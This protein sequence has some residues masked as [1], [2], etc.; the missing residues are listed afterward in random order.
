MRRLNPLTASRGT[1]L[2]LS[3]AGL[4]SLATL[5]SSS[6]ESSSPLPIDSLLPGNGPVCAGRT[7]GPPPLLGKLM[8]AQ[9]QTETKTSETRP[10][11]TKPFVPQPMQAA[12]GD[13]PLYDDLGSLSFKAGTANTKAQAYFDQGL[14][15]AF[16]FNHAEAQRAFRAAYTL[17]PDFAL[18]YWGEAWVLGP[19]INSSMLPEAVAPALAA[20][21]KAVERMPRAPAKDRALIAALQT[22]YSSDPKAERA[23]L[24]VAFADA[25]KAVAAKF[26]K[27]DTL[28]V[29]HAEAVMNTQPWDY[30]EAAGTRSKGRAAEV[31]RALETV[32]ARNPRHPGAIHYYIH[33]VEA[34]NRPERALAHARRLEALM[35][36]AGHL[37]HM[38]SH[39]YH[40]TGYFRESLEANKRAIA[41]DERYFK[42]SASD[43]MYRHG[44]HPHNIHFA[45]ASA[46]M[47]GDG[48][49]ALAMAARLDTALPDD[50]LA[51]FA[52][53]EP[54]KAAP[55]LAHSLFSTADTILAQRMPPKEQVIVSAL[56]HYARALAFAMKRDAS[57]A[58]T[59]IAAIAAIE[60]KA[61]FKAYLDAAVPV[62]EIVQLAR[63]VAS[64]R[65]ADAN[66]DLA[67]A[68][69]LYTEAITIE[70]TLAYSE[71]PYWHV[72]IRQSLG[73]VLLRQGKLDQAEKALRES[74]VRVRG[75]GW[76][77]AGLVAVHKQ[78]G[79]RQ[80]EAAARRAY[81]KAWL[82]AAQ[83]DLARL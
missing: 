47:G 4:V 30:W 63:L 6:V 83:P 13:V 78:R 33:A 79:N 65:L 80:A 57:A 28:K 70:D 81:D 49:T 64:A 41:A 48:E 68:A 58:Q 45:L 19:N 3:L 71:P 20:L 31:L 11:E 60:Q 38:P 23:A 76:A 25:M 9:A 21:G 8:L 16:A 34:S 50:M 24:D 32:L 52:M 15:L 62:K 40:R 18:A 69:Q 73:S 17:D 46:Q 5:T 42:T 61:D 39:I 1:R 2:A 7:A 36:G 22:R 44:Y 72:P 27:D 55:F 14:R 66:G 51:K 75:N 35:P 10:S 29:I 67:G 37:V 43:P 56:A 12:G 53:L 77:L 59:E 26:P 74:L 54:V 82:G